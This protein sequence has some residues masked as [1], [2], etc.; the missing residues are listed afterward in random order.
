MDRNQLAKMIDHTLLAQNATKDQIL[1]LCSEA[2]TFSF[3]SVCVPPCFV[4]FCADELKSSSVKVCTVIGFPL[5][6]N[7]TEVKV[8][9]AENAVKNGADE[10]DMVIN[11]SKAKDHDFSF[12]EQE[13]LKINN[14]IKN[15]SKNLIL[16]VI[17]ETQLLTDEEIIEVCKAA[18]N[19]KADFVKTSTGFAIIKDKNGN[20]MPNGATT[21][22]VKLMKETVGSLCEVKASGGIRDL[23]SALEMINA[24]ATRIGT[25][26]GVKIV[27]AL[28]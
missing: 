27:S 21:H 11:V 10:I 9:E 8:F 26:S 24:G 13:I 2:K 3:A 28:N 1:K 12:I 20:L 19:A 6:A 17:L 18:L 14:A 16:K 25:S 4:K 23:S 5:G 15:L 7:T 22:H